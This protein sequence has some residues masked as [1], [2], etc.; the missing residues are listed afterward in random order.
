MRTPVRNT[1]RLIVPL[2]LFTLL[3]I[4]ACKN[5]DTGPTG[6]KGT[7]GVPGSAN[8]I[9]SNWH[10]TNITARDTTI[11]SSLMKYTIDSVASLTQGIIDSGAVLVYFNFYGSGT[12]SLPYTS[13]AG[14]KANT[15]DFIVTLRKLTYTRFTYDNTASIPLPS[16]LSYRWILI[17]G[18]QKGLPK[19]AGNTAP[20]QTP[21]G[22]A[23]IEALRAMD[24]RQVCEALGI[25]Q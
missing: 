9:Y 10:S 8:V 11:D 7:S 5:G 4:S 2:A 1:T 12:Y 19:A 21:N 22:L 14:G 24:Y 17:P 18:G 16:S 13:F 3:L 20:V 25:P 23:T 15:I 6:P